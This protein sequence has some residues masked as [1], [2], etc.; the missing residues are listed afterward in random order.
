MNR[1]GAEE[2]QGKEAKETESTPIELT[3]APNISIDVNVFSTQYSPR[4]NFSS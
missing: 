4:R 1:L 3:S 2:R